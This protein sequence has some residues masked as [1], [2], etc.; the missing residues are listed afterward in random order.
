MTTK[1]NNPRDM[2]EV[3]NENLAGL[4]TGKRK[5]SVVKDVNNTCARMLDNIKV[6]LIYKTMTQDRSLMPWFESGKMITVR[7]KDVKTN[8]VR[9]LGNKKR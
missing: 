3:L 5:A 6:Q 9:R 2:Q 8:T 1:V 7:A 4:L